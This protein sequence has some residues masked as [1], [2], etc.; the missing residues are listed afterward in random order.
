MMKMNLTPKIVYVCAP[1][2]GNIWKHIGEAIGYARFV[3]KSGAIPIVPHF[4][5]LSLDD[6]N[7]KEREQ[8]LGA[9]LLLLLY[10]DEMWIFGSRITDGMVNEMR[11]CE[12][13]GI[14]M[15]HI[16]NKE[17]EKIIGGKNHEK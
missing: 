14:H 13:T 1:L 3:F 4:Y 9:G 17:Y 6:N 7:P 11:L 12:Q 10:C 2:G 5:A 16:D 8:G 15:R